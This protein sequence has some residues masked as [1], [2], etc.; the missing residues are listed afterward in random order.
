[1]FN[2]I[3]VT[4]HEYHAGAF[5]S[6]DEAIEEAIKQRRSL[7]EDPN[8]TCGGYSLAE[9]IVRDDNDNDGFAAFWIPVEP[10]M[11]DCG[12]E[13]DSAF[14]PFLSPEELGDLIADDGY[15]GHKM[16]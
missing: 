8:Y 15:T 11:A 16:A 6:L 14:V 4:E 13:F 1:M 7:L 10:K 12:A 2:V 9:V 3:V 5:A